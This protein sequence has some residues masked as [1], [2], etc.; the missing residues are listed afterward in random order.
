MRDAIQTALRRVRSRQ[1][2]LFALRCIV[3]GL[4]VGAA[5]GLAV[6]LARVFGLDVSWEVG[7]VAPAAGPVLGL[8]IGLGLRRDWQEAAAAV[9]AHYG[10]KDRAVTAL[11]FASHP[12]PTD[13]QSVQM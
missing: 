12:S 4:S 3:I 7:A 10:L 9:D 2:T 6:G 1:Q 11:A 8:I 13:L 5:G